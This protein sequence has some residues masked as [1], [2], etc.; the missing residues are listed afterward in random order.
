LRRNSIVSSKRNKITEDFE[1]SAKKALSRCIEC[2]GEDKNVECSL[3]RHSTRWALS[4]CADREQGKNSLSFGTE[5]DS[6]EGS[7]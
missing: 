1:G 6:K 4:R 3:R 2:T 5:E 7:S